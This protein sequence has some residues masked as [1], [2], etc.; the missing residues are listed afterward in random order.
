MHPRRRRGSVFNAQRRACAPRG[1]RGPRPP[2]AAWAVGRRVPAGRRAAAH[3]WPP[4]RLPADK[5][6][7]AGG[8]GDAA[9]AA[10]EGRKHL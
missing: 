10:G 2:M 1:R 5:K 4:P 7:A 8:V 3:V 9:A 6:V